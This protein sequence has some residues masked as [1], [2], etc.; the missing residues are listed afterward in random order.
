GL[1]P[2][3]ALAYDKIEVDLIEQ[4]AT[5]GPPTTHVFSYDLTANGATITPPPAAELEP[6]I[7]VS[8]SFDYFLDIPGIDGGSHDAQHPGAFELA[9]YEFDLAPTRPQRAPRG[10]PAR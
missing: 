7:P 1:A 8:T 10:G 2:R 3:T 9:G 5:G 4:S 6:A